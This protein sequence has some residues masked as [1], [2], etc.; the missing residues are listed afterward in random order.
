MSDNKSVAELVRGLQ[1][2]VT[3]KVLSKERISE[4]IEGLVSLGYD[5]YDAKKFPPLSGTS[6]FSGDV[7]SSPSSL[8]E[9]LLWKMG[10][11]GVYQ[12]FAKNYN[13]K[14]FTVSTDGGVVFS[15]F[16]KHL[17]DASNPIYDQ[18]AIRAVWAIRTLSS[19]EKKKCEALLFDKSGS[20]KSA[21]SG[22]DGACYQLFVSHVSSVCDDN[23][24][25]HSSLDKLLMPLGQA[26]KKCTRKKNSPNSKESD[27]QR[28]ISMISR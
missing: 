26:L 6:D 10:K 2:S 23:E 11:W 21:G 18:H 1:A 13:D 19:D 8:A 4:A 5:A 24:I 12:S 20:W 17:Q 25:G 9:A 22:D 7:G 16:A 14:N 15:A 3:N 27:Y 28:F